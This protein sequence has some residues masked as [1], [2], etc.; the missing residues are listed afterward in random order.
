MRRVLG[1][2]AALLAL[3]CADRPQ[4]SAD[5]SCGPTVIEATAEE[6]AVRP[7]VADAHYH[8]VGSVPEQTEFVWIYENHY[9]YAERWDWGVPGEEA[10]QLH[11]GWDWKR[12]CRIER[13]DLPEGT[14]CCYQ[15]CREGGSWGLSY[16]PPDR[17]TCMNRAAGGR[18]QWFLEG[19]QAAGVQNLD[20]C[21]APTG[22]RSPAAPM[23]GAPPVGAE[24]PRGRRSENG[25]DPGSPGRAGGTPTERR[26]HSG[27]TAVD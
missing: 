19:L 13:C 5:P 7:D 27:S 2:G 1:L 10:L 23:L 25:R 4:G 8:F 26:G 17:F 21:L 24:A 16:E 22:A 12:G 9:D 15:V 3:A 11:L 20:A 18:Y 6:E 14:P